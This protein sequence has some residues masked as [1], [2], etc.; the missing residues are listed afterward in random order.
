M[1]RNKETKKQAREAVSEITLFPLENSLDLDINQEV[2]KH[3]IKATNLTIYALNSSNFSIN[4][5]SV[6]S[7]AA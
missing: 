6:F 4:S 5:P 3:H 2:T 7:S 1:N